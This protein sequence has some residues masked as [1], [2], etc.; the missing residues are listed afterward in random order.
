MTSLP[1]PPSFPPFNS[2][3]RFVL[4]PALSLPY[5][6][7]ISC[8]RSPMSTSHTS[9]V[10]WSLL[11]DVALDTGL[12]LVHVFRAADQKWSPLMKRGGLHIKDTGRPRRRLPA[13]LLDH[14]RQ[15][16]CLVEKA[17]LPFR[18]VLFSRIQID[19]PA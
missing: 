6:L 4:V 9:C 16:V 14:H 17:Q 5:Q 3:A 1:L 18:L 8:T 12:R 2:L 15:R 13:R 10:K 11:S 19:S 7:R